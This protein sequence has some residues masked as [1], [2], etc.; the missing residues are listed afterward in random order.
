[1]EGKTRRGNNGGIGRVVV[2][3]IVEIFPVSNL[4]LCVFEN[5]HVSE[6]WLQVEGGSDEMSG[7][8]LLV[9]PCV[10]LL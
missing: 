1:M 5:F 4:W 10:M 9:Y 8:L 2:V 7:G 3:C 6:L